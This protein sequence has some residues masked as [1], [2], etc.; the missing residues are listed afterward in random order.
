MVRGPFVSSCVGSFLPLETKRPFGS[1]QD[2]CATGY[3]VS[4]K[5][6]RA[7]PDTRKA[8]QIAP[9][10]ACCYTKHVGDVSSHPHAHASRDC[11][12]RH[13]PAASALHCPFVFLSRYLHS[14]LGSGLTLSMFTEHPPLEEEVAR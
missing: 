3:I 14:A 12:S 7:D 11:R 9:E 2:G 6:V 1:A 8:V 4:E 5:A 10:L 13:D